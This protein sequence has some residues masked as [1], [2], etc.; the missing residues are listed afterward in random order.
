MNVEYFGILFLQFLLKSEEESFV[1][2]I[3][4]YDVLENFNDNLLACN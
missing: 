3:S 1:F 4:I 2:V